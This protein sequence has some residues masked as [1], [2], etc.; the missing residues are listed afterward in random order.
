MGF[1][2]EGITAA[3]HA[4]NY[5]VPEWIVAAFFLIIALGLVLKW[6]YSKVI[7]AAKAAAEK[8]VKRAIRKEVEDEINRVMGKYLA[9]LMISHTTSSQRQEVTSKNEVDSLTELMRRFGKPSDKSS[10]E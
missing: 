10:P 8:A 4:D 1:A 3:E 5:G 6:A 7:E 9:M 2:N